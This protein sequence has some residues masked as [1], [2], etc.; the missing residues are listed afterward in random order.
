[1]ETMS[2]EGNDLLLV[3]EQIFPGH[4]GSPVFN[5]EGELIG[6]VFASMQTYGGIAIS[7]KDISELLYRFEN[8][9]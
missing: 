1:M 3:S 6:V 9:P 2:E 7:H 4:S 5:Q 8:Q